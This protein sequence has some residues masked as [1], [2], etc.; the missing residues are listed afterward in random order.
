MNHQRDTIETSAHFE[1]KLKRVNENFE[2]FTLKKKT[3]KDRQHLNRVTRALTGALYSKILGTYSIGA[4]IDEI[5]E[6]AQLL[7][8]N[9]S[10]D[11]HN[12]F[13]KQPIGIIT[14]DDLIK[15]FSLAILFRVSADNN[16]FLSELS[17][18]HSN[19]DVLLGTLAAT[20]SQSQYQGSLANTLGYFEFNLPTKVLQEKNDSLRIAY[21]KEYLD[22]YLDIMRGKLVW[23]DS[24]AKGAYLGHWAF[25]VAA[26]VVLLE[27][28]DTDLRDCQFYPKD[29]VD[30]YRSSVTNA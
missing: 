27:L 8:D 16:S 4:P 5:A 11:S 20:V 2:W 9:Y 22:N 30:Y 14:Y 12:H 10:V 6:T 23:P 26:L 17:L 3:P 28:D 29:L 19:E 13:F 1:R 24:H 15:L 7:F 21:L 18:T 25:V